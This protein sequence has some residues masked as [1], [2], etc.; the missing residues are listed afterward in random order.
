MEALAE[1]AFFGLESAAAL[2]SNSRFAEKLHEK[3]VSAEPA[4]Q[5]L[6]NQPHEQFIVTVC[7]RILRE[8]ADEVKFAQCPMCASLLRTPTAQQCPRC[9]QSWHAK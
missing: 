4:V 9:F 7:N 8:H 3:Y 6:L 2:G 1:R 5:A